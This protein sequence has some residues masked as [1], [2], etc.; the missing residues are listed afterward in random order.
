MSLNKTEANYIRL[1]INY[2]YETLAGI[3]ERSVRATHDF[4]N[5]TDLEDIKAAL[6]T[7]YFPNIDIYVVCDNGNIVGFMG[8]GADMIEMLFIDSNMIG[9]GYGSLLIDYAKSKGI[10]KVD[11]NEQNH[12]ALGFYLSKGFRIVGRDATDDA[13]RP[14]PI[15]HL[16]L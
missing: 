14:Y 16:A 4:L 8:L 10:A 1:C 12:A 7:D 2:D 15:L 9:H 5:E 11:V 3:W 13:G 6:I